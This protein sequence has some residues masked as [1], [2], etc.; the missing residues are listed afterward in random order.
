MIFSLR[1]TSTAAPEIEVISGIYAMVRY[2]R[3]PHPALRTISTTTSSLI[4]LEGIAVLAGV[5]RT[6]HH[7]FI[8]VDTPA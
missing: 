8:Y 6:Q 4:L 5:H 3:S 2:M 1:S 7:G